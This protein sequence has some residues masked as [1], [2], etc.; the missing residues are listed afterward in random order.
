MRRFFLL[1][2]LIFFPAEET[3]VPPEPSKMEIYVN[4]WKKELLLMRDGTVI[5]RYP[6]SAGTSDTPTPIGDFRIVQKSAEWGS[7]FG[8]RWLGL[9]VPFGIYGIHGTNKPHLIGRYVSHGCIRMRNRDVEDLYDR[10]SLNTPVRVDGPILGKEELNY[11][12]LVRGSMGSL[13]QLV[14]NRLSAGGYYA[15]PPHGIFDYATEQA[16]KRYQKENGLNVTGQI[17][18]IDLVSLGIVE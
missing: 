10:V 12:I 1:F 11:R 4:L 5:K 17:H 18:F 15:G 14:Q 13:V 3:W 2:L 16:V 9:N 7:G 8:S 6:I